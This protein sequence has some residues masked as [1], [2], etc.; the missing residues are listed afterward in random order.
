MG[1]WAG[2]EER[3]SELSLASCFFVSRRAQSDRVLLSLE[4]VV[5][6]WQE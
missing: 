5:V 2:E 1:G 6:V 4:Q 3:D